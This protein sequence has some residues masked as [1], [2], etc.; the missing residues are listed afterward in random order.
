MLDELRPVAYL[1]TGTLQ[2]K[3]DLVGRIS[4]DEFEA[5]LDA[6]VRARLIEIE[7]S[8]FEKNGEVVRFRKVMLSDTGF[9]CEAVRTARTLARRRNCRGVRCRR[10]AA[11]AIEASSI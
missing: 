2:K 5:L 10:S 6:M 4:R 8:S 1:A 9:D 7:E 3:L 11:T